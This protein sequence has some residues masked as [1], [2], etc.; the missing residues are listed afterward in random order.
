[1]D[2]MWDRQE[3]HGVDSLA[4]Y[5]DGSAPLARVMDNMLDRLELHGVD[6][7]ACYPDGSIGQGDGQH[8]GQAGT[9]L[10]GRVSWKDIIW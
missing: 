1:M 5:P 6:S 4:C 3:L 9:T 2:N 10:V 7:L 8:V